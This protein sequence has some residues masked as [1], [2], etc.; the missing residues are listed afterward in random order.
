[1]K[2]PEVINKV[3]RSTRSVAK[4]LKELLLGEFGGFQNPL[5]RFIELMQCDLDSTDPEN[6]LTE[7]RT[8]YTVL[9]TKLSKNKIQI[10]MLMNFLA[11]SSNMVYLEIE[12]VLKKE[13]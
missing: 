11:K 4:V 9:D 2:L 8:K 1:M 10:R 7:L 5:V 3:Y 6:A 13:L 12:K